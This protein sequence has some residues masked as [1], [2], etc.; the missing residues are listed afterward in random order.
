MSR[1]EAGGKTDECVDDMEHGKRLTCVLIWGRDK[2]CCAY[3]PCVEMGQGM[4]LTV[5]STTWSTGKRLPCVLTWG[6]GKD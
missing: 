1:N 6:K 5:A 4:I 3:A 2:Y